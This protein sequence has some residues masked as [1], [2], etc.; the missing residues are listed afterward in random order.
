MDN[1]TRQIPVQ[2]TG[3]KTLL[4]DPKKAII[5]L[6]MPMIVAM[7]VQTIYNLVDAIWVAGLGTDALAAIG[8]FFP[9]FF[10]I[11]SLATGLGAGG[12]SA[13]SRMIGRRNKKE[14]DDIAAH[15]MV[16]M[17]IMGIVFTIPFFFLSDSLFALLGAGSATAMTVAYARIIFAGTLIIFFA[18]IANAMLRSEGEANKAMWAMIIGG[19]INIVL[20]PI[21]IYTLGL[22]IEGAAWATLISMGITSLLMLRWLFFSRNTYVSFRFRG[23][24]FNSRV[25]KD[26]FRVGLPSSIQH[27]SMSFNMI[28]LNFILVAI[29]GTYGVAV[30]T[31][32]W[33]VATLAVLPIVGI[34]TAM[35]SVSGAA[36]G[37]RKFEKLNI[38][39]NYAMK[40]GLLIEIVLAII[41]FMLA[42]QIAAL[43]TYSEAS[44][45]IVNDLIIFLRIMCIFYPGVALGMLSSAMFQGIG[46]GTKAL[47]VTVYRALIMVP[48]FAFMFPFVFGMGL[49]GVWL[50][51]VTGNIFGVV[52]AFIWA[53]LHIRGLM[54]RSKE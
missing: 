4:G 46:S 11:M 16:M 47:I 36:F 51:I 7:S 52:V 49:Q 26:I 20:D 6:S 42:P 35:I 3:V 45:V 12:G 27:M 15:T 41:V 30:L 10:L 54:K 1:K 29:A 43:F 32:G 38:A 8:F 33:R 40:I 25:I 13:V 24:K 48:L 31:T 28:I 37:E 14:A 21:L 50:G 53:K 9:F 18:N 34:A 39:F 19:I 22:G 5:K 44:A 23:F 2:T 17:L